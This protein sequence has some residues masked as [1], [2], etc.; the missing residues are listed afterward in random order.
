MDPRFTVGIVGAGR[1]GTGIAWTL[2]AHGFPVLL[3]D[4]EAA[5][6]RAGR[7]RIEAMA[8]RMP[9]GALAAGEAEAALGRIGVAEDLG[10]MAAV[11]VAIEAVAEDLLAK[12]SLLRALDTI[13]APD[14]VLATNTS[15]FY[16]TELASV[17][18]RPG[19]TIGLHYFHPVPR[20]PL[21]EVVPGA[22]TRDDVVASM[23]RFARAHGRTPVVARDGPGFAV[24]RFVLPLANEAVRIVEEGVAS[25]PTVDEAARRALGAPFGPFA[26]MNASGVDV[27]L[28]A[29]STLGIEL[30]PFYEPADLL[31]RVAAS[32]EPWDLAG[33]VDEGRLDGVAARLL[34]AV[35][36]ACAQ[37]AAEGIAAPGDV[38]LAA[39]V[40]LR[41]ALGPYE[42]MA[43][44]GA[45]RARAW[46]EATRGRHPDLD[47]PDPIPLPG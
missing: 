22:L 19:Q 23:V 20:N 28:A 18:E 17:T 37:I 4:R 21:V 10:A 44:V 11:R 3:A 25:V 31:R 36:A 9:R 41:W 45:E 29:A 34:G 24:N 7:E 14:A 47:L 15:S 42:R 38:D 46:I 30:G 39:R 35:F 43:D 6:A 13:L 32:G 2:A 5:L 8:D 27:A 12:K 16:V 1:M 33:E 40:G 26:G